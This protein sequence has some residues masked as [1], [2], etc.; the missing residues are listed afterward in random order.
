VDVYQEVLVQSFCMLDDMRG[1][2]GSPV[3]IL[4]DYGLGDRGSIPG[5]GKGFFL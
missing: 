5:S 1:S 4:S 2:R 3:S